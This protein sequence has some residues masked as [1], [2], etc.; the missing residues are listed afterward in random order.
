MHKNTFPI[1][2]FPVKEHDYTVW[3]DYEMLYVVKEINN[4][5]VERLFSIYSESMDDLKLNFADD[6]EMRASYTSFLKDFIGNPKQLVIV[7]KNGDQWVSALRAIETTSGCWFIEAVETKPDERKKGYGKA[8]I[9]NTID[10]L[11]KIGMKEI[12]CTIAQNNFK[13]QELH[14]KCG[15]LPTNEPPINPWGEFEKGTVL[16]RF[17]K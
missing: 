2:F 1:C 9:Y 14:K 11:S 12:T 17:T 7:E 4:E 10:Y 13:S 5:T 6:N 8:L 15:F 16:F 3:S